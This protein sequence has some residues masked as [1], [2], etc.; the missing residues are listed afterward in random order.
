MSEIKKQYNGR[1]EKYMN[2]QN[3][4]YSGKEDDSRMA[5]QALFDFDVDGKTLL[6]AGCG[7]GKD[8]AYFKDLG[9]IVYGI[10]VSEEMIGLV[11]KNNPGIEN[12][13]VQGYDNTSF[14]DNFFDVVH[15]RYAFQY[16]ED[17]DSVFKEMHR[18]I[19]PG[20]YFVFLAAH[21]LL[22]FIAK[23]KRDYNKR[24]TISFPIFDGSFVLYEPSHTVSD[25]LS[26]ALLSGFDLL[27]FSEQ[28]QKENE[29]NFDEIVPDYLVIK[30]RKRHQL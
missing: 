18:I 5:L 7:F 13:F 25:Y 21:P 1:A 22:S 27:H 3:K 17:L 19:K 14:G 10:D 15:S 12:L 23:E 30:L 26:P 20:G 8:L 29:N 24:E 11:R 4:F 28:K 16:S 2:A 6:D 9:A